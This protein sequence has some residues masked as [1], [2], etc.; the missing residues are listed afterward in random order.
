M[1][2][3]WMEGFFSPQFFNS[4]KFTLNLPICSA[5]KRCFYSNPLEG[6]V[7]QSLFLKSFVLFDLEKTKA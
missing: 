7:S 1:T 5:E 3:I 2:W 4:F 6:S